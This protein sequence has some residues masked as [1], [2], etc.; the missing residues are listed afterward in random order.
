VKLIKMFG[1]AA[2]AALMAMAFA[3]ASSAMAGSTQLCTSDP[4]NGTCTTAVTHVHE[5]TLAGEQAI[6]KNS[7]LTV[8]CDVL[9]LS[10]KVG[11]LGAPQVI[12]GEFTYTNCTSGCTVTEESPPA[13]TKILRTASEE[14]TV[15]GEGEVHVN[16]IGLNCYYNGEGLKGAAKGP[17]VSKE[18][19]GEVF[20]NEQVTKK[21]KGLFCPKEGKLTIRTTPLSATSIGI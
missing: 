21:T 4:A 6:L 10:T 19:N 3:G 9:F 13:T 7:I 11:A 14:G 12:E 15:T 1:L 8:E 2:L 20:L 18:T 17:L 16:C 5:T